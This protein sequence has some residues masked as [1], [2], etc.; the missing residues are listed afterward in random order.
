MP[1]GSLTS[2]RRSGT[3]SIELEELLDAQGLARA[4][5]GRDDD[6]DGRRRRPSS[7]LPHRDPTGAGGRDRDRRPR[8]VV[9]LSARADPV[10]RAAT[11]RCASSRCSCDGRVELEVAHGPAVDDDAQL[12][13]RTTRSRSAGRACRGRRCA[14]HRAP[15]LRLR[16]VSCASTRDSVEIF[17]PGPIVDDVATPLR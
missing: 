12:P 8:V 13:R 7:C 16:R 9:D 2:P 15:P 10:H 3:S 1:S 6:H 5:P 4:R 14:A 17:T 11:R